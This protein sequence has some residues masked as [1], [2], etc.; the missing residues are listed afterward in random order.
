MSS[1]SQVLIFGLRCMVLEDS[2]RPFAGQVFTVKQ[3]LQMELSASQRRTLVAGSVGNVMEWYDFALYGFFAPI[4]AKQFFPSED[5]L[6]SLVSTFG[7]FA[8]GYLMRPVGG[9]VLGRLGDRVGR[10]RAL[11]L[12]IYMMAIPTALIGLLPTHAQ[13]GVGASVLLMILR[14]VQGFSVGGEFTGSISFLAEHAPPERRGFFSSFTTGAAVTGILLGSAVGALTTGLLDSDSLNSWGWRVPFLAGVVLAFIGGFLRRTLDE[15]ESFKKLQTEGDTVESPLRE[16][17]TTHG[18]STLKVFLAMW[19]FAGSFYMVFI[20]LTTYLSSE[21]HILLSMALRLN[22]AAMVLLLL[23][24]PLM[25]ILSDK[26]GRKPLL[27]G[28]SACF[29]LFG[30]PLFQ[31]MQKESSGLDLMALAVFAILTAALQGSMPAMIAELFPTRVRMTAVSTAYNLGQ[32]FFGGTAPLVCTYL[33][34]KTGSPMAPAGYL[35]FIS[36]VGT[37]AFMTLPETRKTDSEE[38]QLF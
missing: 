33:I 26:V 10:K 14:M 3:R 1:P 22:T 35:V 15:S 7:V 36:V 5:H 30:Y 24:I 25:G 32:A 34:E 18:A 12:S 21:T 2:R 38:A 13:I 4:I 29:A 16:V 17:L 9:L 6:A 8:A 11:L 27:V 28:A 23:L 20:Y 19:L 31:V 37:I